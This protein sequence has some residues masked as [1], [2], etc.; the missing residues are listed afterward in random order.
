VLRPEGA[1]D[2]AAD[3]FGVGIGTDGLER[4]GR[5]VEAGGDLGVLGED[6]PV[7]REPA[8][9]VAGADGVRPERVVG[10]QPIQRESVRGGYPAAPGRDRLR[11]AGRQRQPGGAQPSPRTERRSSPR[12]GSAAAVGDR[13]VM[14]PPESRLGDAGSRLLN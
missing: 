13:C 9:E 12:P 5:L 10:L 4:R 1:D 7:E 6:L 14:A 2:R 11:P 8:V 3:E